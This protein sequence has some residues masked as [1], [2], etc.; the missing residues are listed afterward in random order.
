MKTKKEYSREQQTVFFFFFTRDA[1]FKNNFNNVR[2]QKRYLI[3]TIPSTQCPA[4]SFLLKITLL[5]VTSYFSYYVFI[6]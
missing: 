5:S 4:T 3:I 6:G 2:L 1:R